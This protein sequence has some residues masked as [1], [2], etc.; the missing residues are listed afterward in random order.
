MHKKG[1]IDE[2][3]NY[4]GITL[5]STFGK[6]FTK[7]INKWRNVWAEKYHVYIEAQAGFRKNMGTVD[8]IFILHGV[9]T[10]LLNNNKKL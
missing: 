4:R 3:S 9:I 2:P 7:I 6:L 10:H 8:N 1:D 5:L